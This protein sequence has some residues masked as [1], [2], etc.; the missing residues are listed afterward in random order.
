M[1]CS[2]Q[3][4]KLFPPYVQCSTSCSLN[5]ECGGHKKYPLAS[6]KIFLI[7]FSL[8]ELECIFHRMRTNATV[9]MHR[10]TLLSFGELHALVGSQA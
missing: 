7:V 8:V 3:A 10:R 2:R 1:C 6:Q 9:C 5:R 4:A